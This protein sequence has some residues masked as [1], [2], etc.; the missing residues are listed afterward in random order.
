MGLT[1]VTVPS[2]SI[3]ALLRTCGQ[4][5][6]THLALVQTVLVMAAM[7]GDTGRYQE[8][9]QRAQGLH[10]VS[11]VPLWRCLADVVRAMLYPVEEED[12]ER[13]RVER[14]VQRVEEAIA[15]FKTVLEHVEVRG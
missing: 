14:E 3:E 2:R 8:A 4:D 13:R 6:R 7:G 5:P 1:H 11:G 15:R 10:D 12:G 9:L